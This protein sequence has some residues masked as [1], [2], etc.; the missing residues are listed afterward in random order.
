METI[1]AFKEAWEAAEVACLT[2]DRDRKL[3]AMGIERDENEEKEQEQ[4]M[5]DALEAMELDVDYFD[6]QMM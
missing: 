6:N 4:E 1:L 2:A 5:I 3:E